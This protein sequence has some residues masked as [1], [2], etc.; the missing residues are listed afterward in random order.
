MDGK[1]NQDDPITAR[2]DR[3]GSLWLRGYTY[4]EIADVVGI[5]V[6]NVG[7][8]LHHIR[9]LWVERS[10]RNVGEI[11]AEE[12]AKLDAL[13]WEYWQAWRRSVGEM[14]KTVESTTKGEDT[15]TITKETE[16]G[17]PRYLQGVERCIEE[18]CD[19]L[20]LRAPQRSEVA[21]TVVYVDSELGK[22]V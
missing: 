15:I 4:K 10:G 11:R 17:D 13:E 2:R 16:A 6:S 18:R 22:E 14:T 1:E 8:D 20:G 5:T 21:Q 7:N 9:Q 3:V 12:L 19:I